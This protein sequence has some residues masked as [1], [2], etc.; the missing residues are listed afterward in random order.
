MINKLIAVVELYYG[1]GND[2]Y[3]QSCLSWLK[4]LKQRKRIGWKPS[5]EQLRALR[6]LTITGNISNVGQAQALIELHNQLKTL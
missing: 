5:E 6:D 2:L 3:K 1:I 4:S